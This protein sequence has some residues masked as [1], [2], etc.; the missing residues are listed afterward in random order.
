MYYHGT[1]H[2]CECELK[3]FVILPMTHGPSML[4][5]ITESAI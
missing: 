3:M 2:L 5:K 1:I 4:Q